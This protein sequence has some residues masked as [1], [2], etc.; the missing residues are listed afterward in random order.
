MCA[1]LLSNRD[2][3]AVPPSL[4]DTLFG[5]GISR[6]VLMGLMVALLAA[7]LYRLRPKADPTGEGQSLL[8]NASS[9][10]ARYDGSNGKGP[11]GL[12]KK[13]R[14]AQSSGWFDYISGFRVLFPYLWYETR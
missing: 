11:G 12:A 14:D 9:P 6:I 7:Q 4:I 2:A 8:G 10:A 1:V 3:I 5:L 13:P